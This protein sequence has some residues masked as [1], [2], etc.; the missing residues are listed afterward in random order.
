MFLLTRCPQWQLSNQTFFFLNSK[1]SIISLGILLH[2]P[3][4]SASSVAEE[5]SRSRV[6][7]RPSHPSNLHRQRSN[8]RRIPVEFMDSRAQIQTDDESFKPKPVPTKAMKVLGYYDSDT[9]S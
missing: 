5:S 6:L 9:A 4:Y 7:S 1:S 3:S 2:M 8:S